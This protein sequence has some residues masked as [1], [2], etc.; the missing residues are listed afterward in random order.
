MHALTVTFRGLRWMV[1]LPFGLV[2]SRVVFAMV[3]VLTF[4]LAEAQGRPKDEGFVLLLLY[5]VFWFAARIIAFRLRP[6]TA[7]PRIGKPPKPEKP[8]ATVQAAVAVKPP[9]RRASP[10]LRE[11]DKRLPPELRA[12][13]RS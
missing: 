9:S 1:W 10:S 8:V 5:A 13:M 6:A 7:R 11:I 12:L 2:A 4:Y 3:A